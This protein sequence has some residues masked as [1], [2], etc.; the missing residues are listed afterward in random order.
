[1]ADDYK[2]IKKHY[3][4]KFA[5][6]CRTEFPDLIAKEKLFDILES[7]FAYN[8]YLLDDLVEHSRV[9]EFKM[10]ILKL[11]TGKKPKRKETDK[12]PFELIKEAGY[13]LYEC[14]SEK[15]IQSF[16]KYYNKLNKNYT[17]YRD[18]IPQFVGEE[19]CTFN[20]DRLKRCHVFFAVRDD[21]DKIKRCP[22]PER[23]DKYGT[24]VMSIQ[25]SKD[26]SHILSIKCRYN[27]TV[28]NPDN[29]LNNNL[30]NII[31]GLTD[32]IEKYLDIK[33]NSN[34]NYF[35]LDG[36]VRASDGKF[37]K[38]SVEVGNNY[39]C[40]LNRK[41]IYGTDIHDAI[42]STIMMDN[43]LLWNSSNSKFISSEFDL[44]NFGISIRDIESIEI[45]TESRKEVKERVI[46]INGDIII[47]LDKFNRIVEFVDNHLT[48]IYDNFMKYNQTL[49]RFEANN[50]E[51]IGENC[52]QHNNA[53][54][55]VRLPKVKEINSGFIEYNTRLRVFDTPEL[56]KLYDQSFLE[57]YLETL[58]EFNAP[59]LEFYR[60]RELDE[61]FKEKG[62]NDDKGK[63]YK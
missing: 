3:G 37:Y 31:E 51:Y 22:I 44:D 12:S 17:S 7:K 61:K 20:G 54:E 50:L 56:E 15:D 36:Y 52:L 47:V 1:M 13:T 23:D 45:D 30:D 55:E 28:K 10:Y 11:A 53:L 14:K 16:R 40:P 18:G 6:F 43:H 59:K 4:E 62:K 34:D 21:V 41:I 25:I 9:T 19:L 49:R 32:S 42:D 46:T 8:K 26:D 33:I 35:D 63:G 24:S 57:R 48:I 29:T 39:I 58:E 38:Y 2:R 5:Q 27:H 60:L